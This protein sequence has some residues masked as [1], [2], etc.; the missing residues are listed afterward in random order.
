M[1]RRNNLCGR[2]A[3]AVWERCCEAFL[4][5]IQ[6]D[7]LIPS[8]SIGAIFKFVRVFLCPNHTTRNPVSPNSEQDTVMDWKR[9]V[10][11]HIVTLSIVLASWGDMRQVT[12]NRVRSGALIDVRTCRYVCRIFLQ[13]GNLSLGTALNEFLVCT[14]IE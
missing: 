10:S 12:G 11:V 4:R 13:A 3:C 8:L 5:N 1:V 2:D 7:H 9:C 6:R 14:S